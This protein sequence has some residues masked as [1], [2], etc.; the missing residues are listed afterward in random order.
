MADGPVFTQI[1]RGFLR[2]L[3]L[4]VVYLSLNHSLA[5]AQAVVVKKQGGAEASIQAMVD[6]KLTPVNSTRALNKAELSVVRVLVVYRGYGGIPLE[7]VGMGSG[8]V[9]APGKI[10][11]NYHV[12]ETPPQASSAEIYIVPHKGVEATYQAVKLEKAWP[13]GDLALLSATD[14]AI[15][16][17]QLYLMPQKNQHVIAMGFPG[18][19]DHLLNR[20]GT[21]LLDPADAYVTQGYVAMQAQSNPDGNAVAT[22]FH[23]API[24]PGN[25]GGPLLNECGQVIGINTWS[26]NTTVSDTGDVDV[27]AGQYVAT[28][29]KA[30]SAF[31]KQSGITASTVSTSCYAKSEDEIVKDDALLKALNAAASAQKARLLDQQKAEQAQSVMAKLQLAALIVLSLLVLCL[32][33]LLI[34][35]GPHREKLAPTA[36]DVTTADAIS[37]STKPHPKPWGLIIL[38]LLVVLVAI[39]FVFGQSKIMSM[40]KLSKTPIETTLFQKSSKSD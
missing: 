28:H 30:L 19:T 29:V 25:S 37:A 24:N 4:V 8:F 35:R 31:L 14:L 20:G 10:I 36:F 33:A 7:A 3:M 40:L 16:P 12:I 17:L 9:V 34:H 15:A 39:G 22:I 27:P 11:T 13:E 2:I 18:V 32:I 5:V 21:E 6:P 38:G 1:R 23:T 26:A